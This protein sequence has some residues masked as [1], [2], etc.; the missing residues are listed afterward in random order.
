MRANEIV[1]LR[2][3]HVLS[4]RIAW[5][6]KGKKPRRISV[7]AN[8]AD[9]LQRW[10]RHCVLQIETGS[11]LDHPDGHPRQHSAE[12]R[13]TPPRHQPHQAHQLPGAPACS[14]SGEHAE[15]TSGTRPPMTCT[16]PQRP[17]P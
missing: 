10:C 16:D 4:G 2:G 3:R 6:G 12:R 1:N 5:T 13:A 17:A 14:S 15:R 8:L 11:P 9:H 7:G